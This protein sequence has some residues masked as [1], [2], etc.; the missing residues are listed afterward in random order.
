MR[1]S[2]LPN[3]GHWVV[4]LVFGLVCL[5]ATLEQLP[6]CHFGDMRQRRPWCYCYITGRAS[7]FPGCPHPWAQAPGP[8]ELSPCPQW[9][10]RKR[11]DVRSLSL[12]R[13][14]PLA[15]PRS[16]AGKCPRAFLSVV[17]TCVGLPNQ[18]TSDR[19]FYLLICKWASS[20]QSLKIVV[21]VKLNPEQSVWLTARAQQ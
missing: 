10:L 4:N 2:D 9:A 13:P 3:Q 15:G 6:L 18:H 1:L 8:Q 5:P 12:W 7:P 21:R 11:G 14:P 19:S 16:A 20:S 17:R